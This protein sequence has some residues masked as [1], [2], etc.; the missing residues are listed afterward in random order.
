M[1]Y[2]RLNGDLAAG[3]QPQVNEI[4]DLA[5][6]GFASVYSVSNDAEALANTSFKE[7]GARVR[8][9]GMDYLYWPLPVSAEL[10]ERAVDQFLTKLRF[11]T[12]PTYVFGADPN[13]AITL[14][15][16][17]LAVA[18]GWTGEEMLKQ[19]ETL[20]VEFRHQPTGQFLKK[21]ID[22]RS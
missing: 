4:E 21:F 11:M 10:N 8:E 9:F 13:R 3:K 14:A 19:A 1:Q 20:G 2:V 17:A 6:D 7:I 5:N 12:A 16:A 15:L 18:E 22:G